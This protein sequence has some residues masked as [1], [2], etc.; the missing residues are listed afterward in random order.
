MSDRDLEILAFIQLALGAALAAF[1]IWLFVRVVN[2][3]ERWAI[4]TLIG[5]AVAVVL[6][7]LLQQD[8]RPPPPPV[9]VTSGNSPNQ[10]NQP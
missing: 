7:W 8:H 5:V 4:C 9:P 6:G 2:R 3:R 10:P 1:C